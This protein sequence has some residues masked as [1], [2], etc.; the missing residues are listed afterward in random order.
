MEAWRACHAAVAGFCSVISGTAVHGDGLASDE[1]AVGGGQEHQRP[2]QVLRVFVALERAP[3]QRR[4][5]R[6]R[7]MAWV[8]VDHAVA[9]REPRRQVVDADIVLAEF[10]R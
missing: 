7:E 4:R 1:I 6:M 9:E 10:P 3:R 2:E 5:L 8:L